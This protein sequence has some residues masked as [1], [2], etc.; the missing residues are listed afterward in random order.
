MGTVRRMTLIGL[1]LLV[2]VVGLGIP[3]SGAAR[4]G[5]ESKRVIEVEGP[6]V[7]AVQLSD[8]HFSV[9]HPDRALD[10]RRLVGP[11]LSLIRPS[12]VLLTGDLTDGKS[13]DLLTM[14]QNEE[15]WVEY[16]SVMDDV[17]Q[18]SGL[19]RTIF[20]DVRGNHDNFG[21]PAVGGALDFFSK[22]SI[23]GRLG[24]RSNVN[25]VTLQTPERKHLFVGLDS[26]MRVG[27]RGPTNLFGHPTDEM[28]AETDAQLS[29]WDSLS[30]K[31]VTKIS[32]GH[33]PLSFSAASDSGKT[34]KEIFL[35]HSISAYICGHLHSRFGKNLKRHHRS[36]DRV[37][38]SE[39]FFQLNMKPQASATTQNCSLGAPP[40]EEFWEWEM[41]DW[42][43][44][45]MMRI[46]AIDGGH[47]SYMDI[48]LKSG[49]K[50]TIIL[51]TFPL[52]SRFMSTSLSH[53]TY[54][55][56][57]MVPS[58]HETIRA[59]VFSNSPIASVIVRIFDLRGGDFSMVMDSQMTKREDI[60]SGGALYSAP[61]NYRA[62]EDPSP[63]RYWLQ[64]IAN[65]AMGRPTFTDLRP[66]SIN[67]LSAHR[68]WTWKEFF[69]MGCQ[70]A[71]LYGPILWSVFC[72]L[73]SLL[74]IPKVL[75]LCTNKQLTY[76]SSLANKSIFSGVAWILQELC[77]IPVVWFGFLGYLFF[78]LLFPWFI[79]QVF[80]NGGKGYMTYKGWVVKSISQRGG[81]FFLGHPDIMVIVIP[82]LVFVVLPAVLVAAALAAER[83]RYQEK[84]RTTMEKKEDDYS[85]LHKGSVKHD[86]QGSRTS[87]FRFGNR[88]TQKFLL[89]V[90]LGIFWK[91]FSNC[92]ALIKAYEM[93]PFFHFPLYSFSVP[94]LLAYSMY[95]TGRVG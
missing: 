23:N 93:N 80:T 17:I 72:F 67:G 18:R 51:P 57:F 85:L 78:L 48:D 35:K 58:S 95:D 84:F 39:R 79:G 14:K 15:E 4:T 3:T 70:W 81:N 89:V 6:V 60:T 31:P 29:Q 34:L 43:K 19:D 8:L 86:I 71:A 25:S 32:F 47:V 44:S 7:W 59:L 36:S 62:F 22:Y 37:L 13:R 12:L 77:N 68:S 9:H 11:A 27:I 10:F 46:L 69:V 16:Q 42:R 65:D 49:L 28:L 53:R 41:G 30:G 92:R 45:R 33:F 76:A 87:K 38:S 1:F 90:C 50:E 61:W 56:E 26:S 2:A 82:H 75:W 21:V 91:H 94:L 54:E 74:L 66:F 83:T 88:W 40:A 24:R 64:I 63:D 20:Y 55:C 52:D 73:F 5:D